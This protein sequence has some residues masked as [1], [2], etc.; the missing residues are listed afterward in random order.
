MSELG[1][2]VKL[3][4]QDVCIAPESRDHRSS[5]IKSMGELHIVSQGVFAVANACP[6]AMAVAGE[7]WPLVEKLTELFNDFSQVRDVF[8]DDPLC[9]SASRDRLLGPGLLSVASFFGSVI[10]YLA[11]ACVDPYACPCA[12]S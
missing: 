2:D 12:M 9:L 10:T 3:V 6:C 5:F 8:L 11:L 4:T 1:G 7:R